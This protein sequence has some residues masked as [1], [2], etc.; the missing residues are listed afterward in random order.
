VTWSDEIG[1]ANISDV[2][3]HSGFKGEKEE[4]PQSGF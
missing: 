2:K 4:K 1:F 3:P